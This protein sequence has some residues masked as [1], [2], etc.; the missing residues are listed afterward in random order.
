[1]RVLVTF[2]PE[3]MEGAL[4]AIPTARESGVDLTWVTWRGFYVPGGLDDAQYRAWVDV[5]EQVGRSSAWERARV[6]NRLQPFFMV[7]P[8][9][10]AFVAAQVE[11][12]RAMSRELGLIE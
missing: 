11:E 9:F 10:A 12:F 5:L 3:R 1:M 2:A 4:A 8:D 7:G 6:V